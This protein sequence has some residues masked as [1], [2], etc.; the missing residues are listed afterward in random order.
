VAGYNSYNCQGIAEVTVTV[1]G[2]ITATANPSTVCAGSSST[3]TASG[4]TNYHWNTGETTASITVSPTQ[5]TTYTVTGDGGSGCSGT[6]SVTVSV[7]QPPTVTASASPATI[8]PGASSTLTATGNA[9]VYQWN[10]GQT[11][12]TITVSPSATTTYFVAGYNSF[13]C[14][15]IAQVDVTVDASAC[16]GSGARISA[17]E[18]PQTNANEDSSDAIVI[19]PNPSTGVAYIKNAPINGMVEVY[20]QIG[21]RVATSTIE[22]GSVEINLLSQAKGVYFI[23]ISQFG[24]PVYQGRVSKIE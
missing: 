11:G 3:I 10:T 16:S 19:Y 9:N 20:N 1:S 18:Q 12:Q 15:T 14:R 17:D 6:A 23:K 7:S 21:Q 24:K 22:N 4:G 13:N 2:G 8:C 5:Q